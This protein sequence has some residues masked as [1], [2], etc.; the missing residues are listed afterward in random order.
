MILRILRKREAQTYA[1]G[2][3]ILNYL[4]FKHKME[5]DLNKGIKTDVKQFHEKVLRLIAETNLYVRC[6]ISQTY[7]GKGKSW[8]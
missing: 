2:E 3:I 8:S 4:R 7:L 1:R 5:E 6:V